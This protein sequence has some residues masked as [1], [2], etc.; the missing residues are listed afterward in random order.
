[1]SSRLTY[2]VRRR[3]LHAS[4]RQ[5]RCWMQAMPAGPLA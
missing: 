5:N 1:L 4:V 2:H 3:R